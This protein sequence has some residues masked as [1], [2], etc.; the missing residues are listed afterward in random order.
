VGRLS[1]AMALAVAVATAAALVAGCTGKAPAPEPPLPKVHQLDGRYTVHGI[2]P[3][4]N[5]GAPCKAADA[6]Y[7][8]I[9][10]GTP[11]VVRDPSGAVV[12]SAKL[13]SGTLHQQPL[14]GRDDDC[15]FRFALTVPDRAQYKI[16]VSIR[17]VVAFSK[18]DL[19]RAHWTANLT[20]G[21]YTAFGGD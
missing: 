2:F 5:Y 7:A 17:G 18:A 13:G 6:G 20:I 16:E 14:R 8:D 15:L 4:R 10:A 12:G 1:S 11:V 3:H 9:H 21:A 19:E